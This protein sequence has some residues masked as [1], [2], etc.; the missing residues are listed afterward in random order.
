MSTMPSP[1]Q[2][3]QQQ[4]NEAHVTAPL[5]RSLAPLLAVVAGM[6]D[7]IGFLS[8]GLFTAHV[9]GNLVVIA[10]L[11]VRGGPPNLTQILA[12]P[13][14]IIAVAAVWLIAKASGQRGPALARPLLL[15]QFLLLMC[16]LIFS[17]THDPAANPHGLM[18]GIAA[19]IAVSAMASQFALLRLAMPVAPSTAVMTGNLTN[20]VLSLLDT[21]SRSKPL[22]EGAPE[23]LKN[24]LELVIGFF[25]G[26]LVGAAAVSWLGD[27]AWSLPVV[28]AAVAVALSK[29]KFPVRDGTANASHARQQ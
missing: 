13:M 29:N 7:V 21:L 19:M 17:V 14:F 20:T 26:C 15:V 18:A 11:L 6:V 24:T 27:W 9:T 4:S 12:V 10:A 3:R 8:L 22:M 5:R 25:A 1:L 28:L 16:V 2:P 23:R